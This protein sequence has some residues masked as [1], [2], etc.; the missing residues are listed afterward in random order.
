MK[1]YK[2][3][4]VTLFVVSVNCHAQDDID[5]D[6]FISDL[7]KAIKNK[8][9]GVTVKSVIPNDAVT[10]QAW[11]DAI[12]KTPQDFAIVAVDANGKPVDIFGASTPFEKTNDSITVP[13]YTL[14]RGGSYKMV[15]AAGWAEAAYAIAETKST[16]PT[17]SSSIAKAVGTI[18]N[19]TDYIA[20]ELCPKRSRPTKLT[21]NLNAGFELVFNASTGSE[22]EWDLE[23]VCKR[24]K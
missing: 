2:L 18:T 21:L 15:G 5:M 16:A 23:I 6:K 22:V 17:P 4:T 12:T 10:N 24:Y 11:V 14:P 9:K 13:G 8:N 7:N 1:L 19:A 3:I 20:K